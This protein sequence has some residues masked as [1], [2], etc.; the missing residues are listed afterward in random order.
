MHVGV[1][2][3]SLTAWGIGGLRGARTSPK[4]STHRSGRFLTQFHLKPTGFPS[5]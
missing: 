1:D 5:D 2:D 3:F 4:R